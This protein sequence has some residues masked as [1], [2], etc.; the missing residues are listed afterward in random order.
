MDHNNELLTGNFK[1]NLLK[2]SIPTMLGFVLQAVYDMVDMIWVG[3]I[4]SSAVAG[5]T[6]FSTVFWLVNIL[7]DVIGTS[8]ISLITQ[9]YGKND[10]DRSRKIV[11]QTLAFKGLVAVITAIIFSVLLKPLLNFFTDDPEVLKAALDYGYIRMFF[12]PIMF[13]SYS[14]NTA[15]R[16]LGDA[17]TPMKIMIISSVANI[18]LD[19]IFMFDKIPG[20]NIPGL[21]MGVFGAA[22][23]TVISIVI[24]FILGFYVLLKGN[25]KL[26]ITI[27]GLF[28][29]DW[30]IDKKLLTIGLPTGIEMLMRNLSSVVTLKFISLYGTNVVAA[31]G[32]GGRIF[33]FAFMPLMGINM[34]ASTI[35][36]Q[37]LGANDI[38]RAKETARFSSL[39]NVIMM[40]V[41]TLFAIIFPEQIMKIFIN[42]PDVILIGNTM[43]RVLTPALILAGISMGLGTV[44]TGS[45]HN[46]PFLIASI[47]S[48]WAIQVPILYF[49]T[50]VFHLPIII[51]WFSY[52][53]AEVVEFLIV[54]IEYKRGVWETKRV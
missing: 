30:E 1:K 34:G 28:Q 45:G 10:V 39:I 31:M 43:V 12:L 33:N 23:A 14:V 49:S 48:R 16:C 35:V 52:V 9:S 40:G 44:F 19:P 42:D 8:S 47:L 38:D 18:I 22:L 17:K 2:M 11:E 4:S 50:R 26:K 6:I 7:N 36:G 13:S 32:I 15:L 5:V 53:A 27:K 21:N 54:S 37:A 51:I 29:L 46:I 3:R 24:S 25:E 41:L 20:T